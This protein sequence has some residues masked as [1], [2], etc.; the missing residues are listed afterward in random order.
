VQSAT[1]DDVVMMSDWCASPMHP[2]IEERCLTVARTTT[3]LAN[4]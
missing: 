2:M 1:D 3:Q 4:Y